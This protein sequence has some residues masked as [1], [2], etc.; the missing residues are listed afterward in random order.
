MEEIQMSDTPRTDKARAESQKSIWTNKDTTTLETVSI[1]FAKE[2]ERENNEL[3]ELVN[4]I[5]KQEE[6]DSGRIFYPNQIS[7]CRCLDAKRIGEITEK[8][9]KTPHIKQGE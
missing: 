2:L 9:R 5:T 1:Y 8:Y 6:S 3:R 4:L 7:S